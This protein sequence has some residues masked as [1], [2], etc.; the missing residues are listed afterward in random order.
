[1]QYL[2]S[3]NQA[4]ATRERRLRASGT[5]TAAVTTV[6]AVVNSATN[7]VPSFTATPRPTTANYAPA[8]PLSAAVVTSSSPPTSPLARPAA[9]TISTG[10][11]ATVSGSD[12]VTFDMLMKEWLTPEGYAQLDRE[13][14]ELDDFEFIDAP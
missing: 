10:L 11:G 13:M 7:C 6:S 12:N 9:D 4:I 8:C 2:L 5:P 1:V 14:G 3:I